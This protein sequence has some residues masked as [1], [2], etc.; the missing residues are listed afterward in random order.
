MCLQWIVTVQ[1]VKKYR[2]GQFC[3]LTNM[4]ENF[5][6]SSFSKIVNFLSL[7]VYLV[8]VIY[9]LIYY[10][11]PFF[12]LP[13]SHHKHPNLFSKSVSVYLFKFHHKFLLLYTNL[14]TVL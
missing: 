10:Y 7:H 12:D 14:N 2:C 3:V 9:V 8:V 11:F 4:C 6:F 5:V 13:S 1:H